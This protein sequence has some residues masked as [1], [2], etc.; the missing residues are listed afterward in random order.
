MMLSLRI[1]RPRPG[2]RDSLTRKPS[3]SGPRCCIAAA[4]VRT[5]DSAS[6][7]RLANA[8]PQIPHTLLFDLRRAEEGGTRPKEVL[9]Q[10]ESWNLQLVIRIPGQQRAQPKEKEGHRRGGNQGEEGFPFEQETPV[11]GFLPVRTYGVEQGAKMKSIQREPRKAHMREAPVVVLLRIVRQEA[12]CLRE[13]HWV[14][15]FDA[16][17]QVPLQVA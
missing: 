7:V 1:P 4:I 16:R 10:V 17:E 13:H 15:E 5:R 8:T 2:A 3:S 9:A 6:A 11:Q 14:L 12:R